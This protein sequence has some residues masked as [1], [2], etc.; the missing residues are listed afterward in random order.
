MTDVLWT[1]HGVRR[2]PELFVVPWSL[3]IDRQRGYS[4]CD[5][6][7]YTPL[8]YCSSMLTSIDLVL[9]YARSGDTQRVLSEN[10]AAA[11]G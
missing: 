2:E 10:S 4:F 7:V 9:S 1:G 3:L 6:S 8:D 11:M 5:N